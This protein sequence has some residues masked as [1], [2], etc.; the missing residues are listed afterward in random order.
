[1]RFVGLKQQ[2]WTTNYELKL[3]IADNSLRNTKLTKP[4]ALK[5]CIDFENE[6]LFLENQRV[7]KFTALHFTL[8][9][10]DERELKEKVISRS[11]FQ[12]SVYLG[13]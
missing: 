13:D 12:V 10:I 1:M 3:N 8:I 2:K 6:F 5:E 11:E 4:L 9:I 7:W